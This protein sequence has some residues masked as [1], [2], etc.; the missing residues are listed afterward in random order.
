MRTPN[1][2]LH[3][4]YAQRTLLLLLAL[5]C[6]VLAAL[7]IEIEVVADPGSGPQMQ[8]WAKVLGECDLARVRIRGA[9]GTDQVGIRTEETE[10]TIRYHVTAV[11]D[12]RG[13][14]VLPGGKFTDHQTVALKQ[15]FQELPL[16]Q[17][18]NSVDR[19]RFGLTAAQ[20]ERVFNA[21][22]NPVSLPKEEVSPGA[23]LSSLAKQTRLSVEVPNNIKWQLDDKSPEAVSLPELS[24]GT[25]LAIFLREHSLGMAPEQPRGGELQL[26]IFEL[27][28]DQ[29]A[30]EHWPVGWKSDAI[31]KQLAPNMYRSTAIE[32]NGFQLEETLQ[33][34]GP[35]A[36][37]PLVYDRYVLAR[38][39]IVP[40]KIP[41]KI[42]RKEMLI[43]RGIDLVLRQARLTGDMRV[44]ENGVPFY[45]ITQFGSDSPRASK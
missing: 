30:L 42:D 44:D 34:L 31:G 43:R 17:K 19:G 21:F 26:R 18:H 22:S 3:F 28:A 4:W 13:R 6:P 14:L 35:H 7:P 29:R 9:R 25:T 2:K 37:I 20:F 45:W 38:R 39:K 27:P 32:I 8:R 10:R 1:L 16:E 5:P 15:F 24:L 33:A 11:L 40:E 12:S 41:I 23:L 36:G